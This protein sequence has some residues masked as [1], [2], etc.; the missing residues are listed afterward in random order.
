MTKIALCIGNDDYK[1]P[2]LGKLSGAVNDANA[3]GNSLQT[4]GFEVIIE[5]NVINLATDNLMNVQLRGQND[6][7]HQINYGHDNK[8]NGGFHPYAA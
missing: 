5:T 1:D 6:A 7:A 2:C 3:I 4:V 8:R